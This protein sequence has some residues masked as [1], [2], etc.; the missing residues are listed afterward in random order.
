MDGRSQFW[1]WNVLLHV[2]WGRDALQMDMYIQTMK[3]HTFNLPCFVGSEPLRDYADI[4][5]HTH[6]KHIIYVCSTT[7]HTHAH[8]NICALTRTLVPF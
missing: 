2:W 1:R 8:G 5:M 3:L 7:S 6:T 4:Y